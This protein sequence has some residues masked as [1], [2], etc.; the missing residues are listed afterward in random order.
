MVRGGGWREDGG[1]FVL[2]N[3]WGGGLDQVQGQLWSA[4]S[5]AGVL[6]GLCP[7][8]G[9]VPTGDSPSCKNHL[10][11]FF[12]TNLVKL[13]NE[14]EGRLHNS[15]WIVASF[16]LHQERSVDA[17]PLA[18]S[19]VRALFVGKYYIHCRVPIGII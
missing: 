1:G 3:W 8:K 12:P 9:E 10:Q 2:E 18:S 5:G 17:C 15:P 4:G 6:T 19:Q 7:S 11:S 13:R 16:A 14:S